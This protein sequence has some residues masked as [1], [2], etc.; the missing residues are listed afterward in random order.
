MDTAANT[1]SLATKQLAIA[2][3]LPLT[4]NKSNCPRLIGAKTLLD[5]ENSDTRA[6]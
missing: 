5:S 3:I 6:L 1:V 2:T 4:H